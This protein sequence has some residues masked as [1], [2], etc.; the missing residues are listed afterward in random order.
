MSPPSAACLTFDIEDWYHPELVRSRVP[1]GETRTVVRAG[2]LR[3]TI[4]STP[5][6]AVS[7]TPAVQPTTR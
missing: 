7:H 4:R 6:S 3:T 1:P 2:T 5:G